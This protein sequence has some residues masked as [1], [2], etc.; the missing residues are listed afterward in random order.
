LCN[1]SARGTDI[2]AALTL[3]SMKVKLSN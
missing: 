3:V 1:V 2:C